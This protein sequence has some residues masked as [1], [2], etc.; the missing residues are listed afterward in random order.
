[1]TSKPLQHHIARATAAQHDERTLTGA[2]PT[3]QHFVDQLAAWRFKRRK[4][5][6]PHILFRG[7]SGGT[8]RVLRS[9][10]LGRA[11]PALVDKAARGSTSLSRSSGPNHTTPR[12]RPAVR[13]NRRSPRGRGPWPPGT[14]RRPS[15]SASTPNKT[16]RS[17]STK[18]SN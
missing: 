4:D 7:P 11:D 3:T 5:A 14:A 12:T 10:L 16:G 9:H 2:H 6:G 17:A 8:L 15:C 1:M 18:S 13:P